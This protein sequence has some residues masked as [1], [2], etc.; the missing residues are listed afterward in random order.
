MKTRYGIA[1]TFLYSMVTLALISV[2]LVGYFWIM[3]EYERFKK[4]AAALR[5]QYFA[6][7][8]TLIKHET[9]QVINYI[10]FKQSQAEARLKEVIRDR[11]LEAYDIAVNLYNANKATKNS[12]E[13]KNIIKEAL[14]PIRY[15]HQHG[16]YFITRLDGVEILFADRPEMEGLNLI[17]MQDSQGNFVIR[18][19][20]A[21]IKNSGEGFYSYTWT[22]PDASGKDFPKVAY[23]KHFK[24][25]DWLIGTGAYLDDVVQ[26]IQQ[27]VLARIERITFG[28]DGYIFAGQWDGLSLSGPAKGRNVIDLIDANGVP[29]VRELI[30]ASKSDGGYVS[31]VMPKFNS[32]ST[33]SK[34]SYSTGIPEWKWYVGAGVNADKIETVISQKRIALQQSVKNGIFEIIRILGAILLSVLLIA[35]L[36]SNRIKKNFN[37]FAAF[38][39]KASTGAVEIESENL[40]FTEF[41]TLAMAANRMIRER[42]EAETALRNSERN[43]RE[44]VQS[45]NSIIMRMDT[46]GKVIFF[47][48]YAQNFFGYN[49][50]EIIGKNVIGTIVPQKDRAGFD[51]SVMIK[52]IGTHPERYVSNENENIRRNGEHVRVAWMNRAINDDDGRVKEILCVGI[53][54]TE[55]WQLEKRLAQAQKMEA[56]GTLA[57]G[58]AHDF[59]NIL[60][61]IMGYTEL[62]LID[63]PQ[64]S[65]VRNN[66][67]QVLKAGNRA[68]ELVQQILTYSRQKERERQPVKINLIVN[69]ALKLLRASLPS[70]IQMQNTIQSNLAVMSDPTNI[71]QVIMNL[72]TNASHAMQKNG[73]LLEVNLLDVEL[74]EDFA[75]QHP[76]ITPG[77]F[78]E[79]TVSDTGHGMAPEVL[80]RIFDPFFTTK[81]K[82]EGTGMGLSVVHGIVKSHGGTLTVESYPEKGTVFKAFIPAIESE[83]VPQNES[84][85]LMVTGREHILFVDDEAFQADIAQQMLS[86]LGYRLTTCTSSNGALELFRQSPQEFDLVITDMT[87]PHM[88]GDVLARE[89][90]SIRPDIPIIVCTGYSD[91]MDSEIADEIGIRELVMKP[92]VMK[93]IAQIIRRV[94]DEDIEKPRPSFKIR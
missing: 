45:A 27:E 21:I 75:K 79:L 32:D 88:P 37:L 22:K 91:R 20:I 50:D 33:Y 57:G 87:M 12:S 71:H 3:N 6:D 15:N 47:N 38:F 1:K 29:I 23:V 90:I 78:V 31:Y 59:N 84:A 30:A 36:V 11:T 10:K 81:K 82:G 34:L 24:P 46:E 80:D 28:E 67:K 9:N 7:Q 60:S 86:R 4:E 5:E 92:V 65:P 55:K 61:A 51:L 73:G 94:L 43:Y 89:L 2:G 18:D 52:D 54:V 39:S 85:D 13:I 40:H 70:T 77:K 93:E 19:M 41:E 69:E 76:G 14:R 63:L 44:L 53:D 8:K 48:N 68:K 49:Q 66:L 16:Y 25:F 58:I 83:W 42:N 56:I 74:D 62:T 72:C 35:K 17:D 64:E 26:D